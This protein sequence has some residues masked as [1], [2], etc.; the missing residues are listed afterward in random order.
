MSHFQ[1][2]PD[3]CGHYLCYLSRKHLP[4]RIRVFIDYMA[5]QTR[6]LD[7]QCLTTMTSVPAL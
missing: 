1:Y 2:A 5:E 7:L 3:D 4:S 6:A